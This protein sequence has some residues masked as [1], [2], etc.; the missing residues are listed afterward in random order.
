MK[1]NGV[2]LKRQFN[3]LIQEELSLAAKVKKRRAFLISNASKE[4]LN[5]T[6]KKFTDTEDVQQMLDDIIAIEKAYTAQ[7]QQLGLFR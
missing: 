5:Q 2:D 1:E 7:S 4:V 6:G 3:R